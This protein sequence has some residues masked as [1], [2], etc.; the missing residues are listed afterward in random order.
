MG[1]THEIKA[2]MIAPN[3]LTA[4]TLVIRVPPRAASTDSPPLS[5]LRDDLDRDDSVEPLQLLEGEEYVYQLHL[6]EHPIEPLRLEPTELFFPDNDS[7][8]SGRLRPGLYTGALLIH[9]WSGDTLLGRATFEVRSRK[10]DYISEYRWMLRDVADRLA[11]LVMERFAPTDQRFGLDERRDAPTLYQRFAFLKNLL[12]GESFEKAMHQILAR[13][14][15]AWVTT[16][17]ERRPGQSIP[18]T[19]AVQRQLSRPGRR[20]KWPGHQWPEGPDTLPERVW[21][22]RT[23]ETLDTPEN[24]FI[25]YV[26][27]HFQAFVAQLERALLD[28]AP[29]SPTRRGLREVHAVAGRLDELLCSPLFRDVG[30]MTQFPAASQVLQKREGYRDLFRAYVQFESA[31]LLTW[32][33]GADVYGAGQRDV[34]T[35]YEY[36]VFLKLVEIVARLCEQEFDHSTLFE[37]RNDGMG[38]LLRRGRG[39]GLTGYVTRLGRRLKLELWF[40][41]S[42][43]TRVK[44]EGSWTRPMRPDYSLWIQP[45]PPTGSLVDEVWLHFDAKYRVE[46]LTALFGHNP[47]SK[48]EEAGLLDDEQSATARL[49]PKRVDLL[50]MHAYRDAIRRSAGA[51]VIY[52]GTDKENSKMYHEVLPG[53]GAFALRPT[54]SGEADGTG[55]LEGFVD[56]VL[57][58]IA[59][60][61]TQHER[62]RFWVREANLP[63]QRVESVAPVAPFLTRPP[64]DTLVLLGYVRDE[65]QLQWIHAQQR[66]NLRA[67]DRTG[68]V[69]IESRELAV[70]FVMLYSNFGQELELWRVSG[71]PELWLRERMIATGYRRNPGA[72]YFCLPLKTTDAEAWL[73]GVPR[74]QVFA[75]ARTAKPDVSPGAPVIVSWLQLAARVSGEQAPHGPPS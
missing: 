40:N 9:A 30:G 25:K 60:Q 65:L 23:E 57:T 75:L 63:E 11:E 69:D 24:R 8:E 28:E 48:G 15:R 71:A 49:S 36:W 5:D 50:K 62:T 7:L 1:T 74:D 12:A 64:A 17:E 73:S 47:V 37:V 70:E 32:D 26:L 44:G 38:V 43:S 20:T 6:R 52:P 66:Y 42:F 3:G 13:P 45:D 31:A 55:S 27:S 14:H 61:V 10:V 56:E 46:N 51:Y 19:S 35:L 22:Q 29:T 2:P 68:S 54:E 59:S 53:L 58:H 41:R 4:G 72:A 39:T 18:A 33:G 67:G 21:Y 34:A 16:E